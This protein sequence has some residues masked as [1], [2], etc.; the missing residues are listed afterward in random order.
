LVVAL[1]SAK[2]KIFLDFIVI[3]LRGMQ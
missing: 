1:L 2:I 3:N